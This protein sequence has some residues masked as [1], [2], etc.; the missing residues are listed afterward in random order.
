MEAKYLR[1]PMYSLGAIFSFTTKGKA[2]LGSLHFLHPRY[3]PLP[4]TYPG[5]AEPRRWTAVLLKVPLP[6]QLAQLAHYTESTVGGCRC[7][8]RA[9]LVAVAIDALDS[10]ILPYH[11]TILLYYLDYSRASRP[12]FIPALGPTAAKIPETGI[13]SSISF[14]SVS[15]TLLRFGIHPEASTM[16]KRL[17]KKVSPQWPCTRSKPLAKNLPLPVPRKDQG[18]LSPVAQ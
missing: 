18:F 3:V 14:P 1:I 6:A 11:T 7:C 10:C 16:K 2:P 12:V 9:P 4:P 5:L 15:R 8:Q 13:E 17:D